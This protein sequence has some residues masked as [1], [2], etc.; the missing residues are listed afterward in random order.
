[1]K[2]YRNGLVTSL[3]LTLLFAF[4]AL[5]QQPQ[6]AQ[7]VAPTPAP[8]AKEP[9]YV[10]EK[11]F[12]GKVFEIKHRE[13]ISLYRAI[14]TLGSG[15]KGATMSYSN[16]DKIIV[17]R[18]FPENITAIEEAIKRLDTPQPARP[19]IELHIHFLLASNIE[20]SNNQL[21]SEINE[22]VKQLRATLAYKNYYLASSIIQ[23]TKDGSRGISGFGNAEVGSPLFKDPISLQYQIFSEGISL[24]GSPDAFTIELR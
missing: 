16:E 18:D 7:G 12:K 9:E 22:A 21:P 19:D 4:T 8:S 6:P 14:Y 23:R 17:V 3:V 15:Y 11:G 20:G 10:T 13:P 1:M 2:K 5:A 24:I